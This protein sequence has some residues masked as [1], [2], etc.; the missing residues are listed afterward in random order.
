MPAG[1]SKWYQTFE[2]A[3]SFTAGNNALPLSQTGISATSA[4]TN[5]VRLDVTGDVEAPG[6]TKRNA[7]VMPQS[8][9]IFDAAGFNYLIFYVKDTQGSNTVDV[10][11]TDANGK[12]VDAWTDDTSSVQNIWTKMVLPLD[13]VVSQE[14]DISKITDIRLGEW[15]SGTYYFD[16]LYVAQ[17][18][19]DDIPDNMQAVVSMPAA[20][21]PSGTFS[22]PVSW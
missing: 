9:A 14:L 10:A 1:K 21:P 12:T 7:T 15:N 13:K 8:G 22:A 4:G 5:S 16:D 20:D 19:T 18:T 17:N 6:A 2:K 11:L 3:A